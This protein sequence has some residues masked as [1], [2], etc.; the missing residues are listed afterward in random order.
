MIELEPTSYK[1]YERK[2]AALH[3]AKRYGEAFEAFKMMLS[4]VEES[5]DPQVR[6]GSLLSICV[7]A[8]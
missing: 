2:H 8:L 6:G 1:G 7:E 3:G 5:P 4:K